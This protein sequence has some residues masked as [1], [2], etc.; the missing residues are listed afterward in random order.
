MM[1]I[2]IVVVIIIV[3]IV[4]IV[5]VVVAAAVAADSYSHSSRFRVSALADLDSHQFIFEFWKRSIDDQVTD[6]INFAKIKQKV[7][8]SMED[9]VCSTDI[10]VDTAVVTSTDKAC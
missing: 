8:R 7:T 3:V 9:F 10:F 2:A 6:R 4:F 1:I 5:V